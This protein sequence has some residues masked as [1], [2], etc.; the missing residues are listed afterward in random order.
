M[1]NGPR[2]KTHSM[3]GRK[4]VSI[5]DLNKCCVHGNKKREVITVRIYLHLHVKTRKGNNDSKRR[6]G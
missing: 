3:C 5:V 4:P 6:S 1:K 2:I